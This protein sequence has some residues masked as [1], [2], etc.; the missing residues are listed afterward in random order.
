MQG[1][2]GAEML[3]RFVLLVLPVIQTEVSVKKS[4]KWRPA[5]QHD[6]QRPSAIHKTNSCRLN[7]LTQNAQ[8][9]VCPRRCNMLFA[10]LSGSFGLDSHRKSDVGGA[11]MSIARPIHLVALCAVFLF[12]GAIVF[13][14]I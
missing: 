1:H 14:A 10:S 11:T 13:G 12:I 6:G 7:Y 5:V 4:H 2:V 9:E 8:T 3:S